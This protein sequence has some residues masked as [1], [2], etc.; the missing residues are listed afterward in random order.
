MPRRRAAWASWNYLA[1]RD[2]GREAR[3]CVTYW[4]NKLQGLRGDPLFVTLNSIRP[5]DER[6]VHADFLYHH[7]IFDDRAMAA[8]RGLAAL[9]GIGGI[10][11]C[12][13]YFGYGFHED[14]LTSGLSVAERLGVP[15]P[16]RAAPEDGRARPLATASWRPA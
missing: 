10:W 2:A 5:P 1:E 11:Y 12:G 6:K 16:W 15:A 13:S 8:Q 9:Q 4:M 14:A 7:P 3:L